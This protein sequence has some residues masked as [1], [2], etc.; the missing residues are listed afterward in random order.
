MLAPL[1]RFAPLWPAVRVQSEH[2]PAAPLPPPDGDGTRLIDFGRRVLGRVRVRMR[3]PAGTVLEARFGDGPSAAAIAWQP[4]VDRYTAR[5]QGQEWF[6]P[7]FAVHAFRWVALSGAACDAEIETVLAREIGVDGPSAGSFESDQ[8]TWQAW[9]DAGARIC[10]MGLSLGPV[11]GLGVAQRRYREA[12]LAAIFA[13]ASASLDVAALCAGWLEVIADQLER[14][15]RI[16]AWLPAAA[17]PAPDAYGDYLGAWI[18][19][20][21]RHYRTTDDRRLLQRLAPLVRVDVETWQGPRGSS[22]AGELNDLA[23]FVFRCLVAA[24]IAAILGHHDDL[25]RFEGMGM[26]ARQT[27]RH[28]F[29]SPDGLLL[30]ED[31]LGYLLALA[32]DLLEGAQRPVALGRLHAQLRAD[33]F[34]PRLP[35]RHVPLLLE[36]LC[37]EGRSDL[38][39]RVLQ[40]PPMTEETASAAIAGWLQRM[41]LGLDV[42]DDLV[43]E[44]NA[45]RQARLQPRPPLALDGPERDVPCRV[46]GHLDTVHGRYH[47]GWELSRNELSVHLVVPANCSARVLLPDGSDS[48][49]GSGEH[50]F[51]VSL[52]NTVAE[53]GRGAVRPGLRDAAG[54]G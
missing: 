44:R 16:G 30:S 39:L 46:Q 45:Y 26:A 11:A 51:V 49:V 29:V 9:F 43:P 13:G 10:R 24:R 19:C 50:R 32:L 7:T 31:Q 8:P 27:F 54:R 41:I 5:G 40:H 25:A 1:P 21:W 2:Q 48:L 37:L 38:A 33:D 4:G 17:D 23:W 53:Y 20:L 14:H 12:D 18:P 35:A 3:A 42:D 22:L 15:G 47:G 28:R 34:R 6:E 36:V 52:Q